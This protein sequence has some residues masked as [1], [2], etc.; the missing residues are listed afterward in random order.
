MN[1]PTPA[2]PAKEIIIAAFRFGISG[3][4]DDFARMA[5]VSS[6]SMEIDMKPPIPVSTNTEKRV[7]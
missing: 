1:I 6:I 7:L 5:N 4:S 2:M 3:M